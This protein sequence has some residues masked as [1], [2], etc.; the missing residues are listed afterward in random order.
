MRPK[1][2]DWT[3]SDV[4]KRRRFQWSS[5]VLALAAGLGMA[6]LAL[7]VVALV[8]GVPWRSVLNTMTSGDV[9]PALGL[10]VA[11][12]LI[13]TGLC[14]VL[15]VPLAW[16]M[17]RL[18]SGPARYVR[19]LVLL[20]LVLPPVAGGVALL[21][22]FG[23]NGAI[24][25]ILYQFGISLPFST[26][27]VV[28]S[29]VFVAIPFMIL[30]SEA[31]FRSVDPQQFAVARTLG[32]SQWRQFA[33]V[34]WPLAAPGIAAGALLSWARAFGEFGATVTFAGSLP[35]VTETLPLSVYRAL[36]RDQDAAIALA[37][38]M[39]AMSAAVVLVLG[40]RWLPLGGSGGSD[41][42]RSSREDR[43]SGGISSSDGFD[44]SGASSASDGERTESLDS[45]RGQV[46]FADVPGS[47][48]PLPITELAPDDGKF[49]EKRDESPSP[50]GNGQSENGTVPA[51]DLSAHVRID[52]PDFV[53]DVA[54][55]VSTGEIV[56]VTGSNG[57][58]KSTLLLAIA[59]LVESQSTTVSAGAIQWDDGDSHI[60]VEDR[61]VGWVPQSGQLFEHLSVVD[62]VAFGLRCR[63]E[64]RSS[65]RE[66]A[67][68]IL[69]AHGFSDL[70][71]RKAGTLS[72]GQAR[73][74]ALLRAVAPGPSVLLLDEPTNG[75]DDR[76]RIDL[77]VWLRDWLTRFP[78]PTIV[79]TH[80]QDVARA[81][82]TKRIRMDRGR[83]VAS[84]LW[85]FS[86]LSEESHGSR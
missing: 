13:S 5:F 63:G 50:A 3:V 61:H 49:E 82:Y 48:G 59:G 55:E 25:Q 30:A 19:A 69:A 85:E 24:G 27:A 75:L 65:A 41:R 79:V 6:V 22:L 4:G 15:G 36:E 71:R 56:V 84:E 12:T 39:L 67:G 21:L 62:N 72:G 11:T 83:V 37:V 44:A 2:V 38:V 74:V 51:P 14:L 23:R 31:A 26:A 34:A 1:N 47:S 7:P 8:L 57:A 42:D 20:P 86:E 53:V 28:L 80:D 17:S 52:R 40:G 46:A 29:Q 33:S 81:L 76:A 18:S 60:R 43:E 10:S 16:W 35:G 68:E 78:K 66:S 70:G 73:R 58:G 64:S 54:L 9:G 32:A 77:V 45:R